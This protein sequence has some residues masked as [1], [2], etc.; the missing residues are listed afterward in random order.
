MNRSII[1]SLTALAVFAATG[2]MQA[3]QQAS[4]H[5]PFAAHWG[6]AVMEPGDYRLA[7]PEPAVGNN[8]LQ[9]F[10]QESAFFAMPQV[11]DIGEQLRKGSL[12]L[13]EVDGE[14]F[15]RQCSVASTG[16]TYLFPIPKAKHRQQMAKGGS[17]SVVS[18]AIN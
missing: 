8:L 10:G 14:Y 2:V 1:L 3:A 18:V 11:T 13:V 15:V 5:L 17:T 12:M 6:S 4:F 7:L 9:I 16:K